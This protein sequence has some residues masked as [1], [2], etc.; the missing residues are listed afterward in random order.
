M[1]R[2]SDREA[3][4][5]LEPSVYLQKLYE[6]GT[7]DLG[8]MNQMGEW[9]VRAKPGNL[10]L[11]LK[12]IEIGSYGII[13]EHGGAHRSMAPRGAVISEDLPSLGFTINEKAEVLGRQREPSCTK[14]RSRASG[15]PRAISRGRNSSRCP[16]TSS[17]RCA[18]CARS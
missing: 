14:R 5:K 7:P 3:K 11:R 16:T 4:Y 13:P 6:S 12:D 1:K 10:G 9:G 18:S 2:G 15:A 8:W 17:A